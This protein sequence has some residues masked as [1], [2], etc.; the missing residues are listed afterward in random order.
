MGGSSILWILPD[1]FGQVI[2][3]FGLLRESRNHFRGAQ[4]SQQPG[5][6]CR[7]HSEPFGVMR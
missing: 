3:R 4:V 1:G 5:R 2:L 6:I 7:R